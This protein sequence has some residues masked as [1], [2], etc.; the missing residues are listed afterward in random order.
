MASLR[1]KKDQ[2]LF[3]RARLKKNVCRG[4]DEV[5]RIVNRIAPRASL[6]DKQVSL[7]RMGDNPKRRHP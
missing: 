4:D 2:A 1:I 3:I 5:S 6:I 7:R